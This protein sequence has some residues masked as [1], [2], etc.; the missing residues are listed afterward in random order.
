VQRELAAVDLGRDLILRPETREHTRRERIELDDLSRK[1]V[2]SFAD[3]PDRRR[4]ADLLQRL[5]RR[6]LLA[7]LRTLTSPA[8]SWER[9]RISR[10]V[11]SAAF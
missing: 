11:E 6:E 7:T 10:L 9:L 5:P 1:P 2:D 8:E 4:Q 3:L